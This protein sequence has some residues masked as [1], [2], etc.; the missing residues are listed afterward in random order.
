MSGLE[1]NS[2]SLTAFYDSHD[3]N[4]PLNSPLLVQAVDSNGWIITDGPDSELVGLVD[5]SY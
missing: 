4:F 1:I 2:D 3:A 5:N